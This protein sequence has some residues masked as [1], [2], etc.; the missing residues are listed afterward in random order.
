[1][2]DD[3]LH[4][5]LELASASLDG[6][7]SAEV[8]AQV[9]ADPELAALAQAMAATRL[10]LAAVA[11]PADAV[12]EAALAAALAEF[13][14]VMAAPQ[15]GDVAAAA[16]AAAGAGEGAGEAAGGATVLSFFRR[17][18]GALMAAAAAVVLLGVVGVAVGRLGGSDDETS[19][20]MDEPLATDTLAITAR[21][22]AEMMPA[23][24]PMST[25]GGI[26][27]PA[28]AAIQINDGAEL[29]ALAD[30]FAK[31]ANTSTAPDSTEAPSSTVPGDGDSAGGAGDTPNVMFG[32]TAFPCALGP[33]Q[34]V[35]VDIIWIDTHA[36]AVRDEVSGVVT[37]VADD[38]AVLASVSP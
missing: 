7:V 14:L 36:W 4:P 6:D 3:A 11:P 23:D 22:D 17:R 8:R 27:G 35:L 25:I 10:E 1:M 26:N 12:R 32:P 13:D 2:N 31:V 33:N 16:V 20:A 37:A 5:D 28:M 15:E 19:T 18:G 30:A 24:A 9:A 29:L 34:M 38:C 21:G